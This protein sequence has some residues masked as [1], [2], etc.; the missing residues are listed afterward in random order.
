MEHKGVQLL[1]GLLRASRLLHLLLL[2]MHRLLQ[3]HQ[4]SQVQGYPSSQYLRQA[5]QRNDYNSLL[6]GTL[7]M[8]CKV[9]LFTTR[10]RAG[11]MPNLRKCS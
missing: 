10:V 4:N 2:V 11:G 7:G 8:P 6:E 5:T 9:T 3:V 1:L